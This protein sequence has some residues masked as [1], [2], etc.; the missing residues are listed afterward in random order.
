MNK[1]QMLHDI[2][3]VVITVAVVL[4]AWSFHEY[5]K[6]QYGAEQYHWGWT[7]CGCTKRGEPLRPR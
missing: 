7:D 3:L 6:H 5:D 2:L 4:A 1:K